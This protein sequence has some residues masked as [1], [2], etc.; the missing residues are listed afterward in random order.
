LPAIAIANLRRHQQLQGHV[1]RRRPLARLAASVLATAALLACSRE[2]GPRM[3]D[4][5]YRALAAE[6]AEYLEERHDSLDA[7]FGLDSL[8]HAE[9][10]QET[11]RITFADTVGATPEVV[12]DIQFV[13]SVSKKDGTWLWAWDN[14]SIRDERKDAARRVRAYGERYGIRRLTEA[15]WPAAEK[16]GWEMA[17]IAVRVLDARGVY[18]TEDADSFTFLLLVNVRRPESGVGAA[19][20]EDTAP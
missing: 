18:R 1:T 2:E 15:Q 20:E 19:F 8:A 16:D 3:G 9:W 11:G 13:G 7:A 4:E 5:E 6:S 10:S 12:A 14:P 17:A